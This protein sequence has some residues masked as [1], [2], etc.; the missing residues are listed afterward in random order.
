M[1]FSVSIFENTYL[2]QSRRKLKTSVLVSSNE[3]DLLLSINKNDTQ[4]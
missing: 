1:L 2:T 3:I 4:L